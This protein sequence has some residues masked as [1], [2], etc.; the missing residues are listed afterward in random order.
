LK[1]AR[2]CRNVTSF[3]MHFRLFSLGLLVACLPAGYAQATNDSTPAPAKSAAAERAPVIL[4]S[5]D[6]FRWDYCAQHPNET[7]HF[8]KLASEGVA[9]EGLI[10][11]FPSNTFPNHY[12]I[13]TGLYPSHSGI[14]NNRMF[15]PTLGEKFV[16]K[17]TKSARD[18]RWWGGEPIWITAVKQGRTSACYFWP[19]SEAEIK[20]AHATYWK[21]YD[22]SVAFSKR[23]D[24]LVGWL[25]LPAAER[26]AVVAFYFEETNSTG[27]NFGPESPELP[28][29]LAKLDA[30]LGAM[31][32]RF[33]AEH[34]EVN[35]VLV[36]DHGMTP[37][38][39]KRVIWLNDYID[40]D[41]VQ[42]DFDETVGGI[43]PKPGVDATALVA[44]LSRMPYMHVY[45][46]EDLPARLH[47]DPKNP[48][49][50][51]IWIVPDE[52]AEIQ[53]KSVFKSL[54]SGLLKGQ[55]GYDP[56]FK[57]MHGIFIAHGPAF[58]R[59]VTVPEVEN[60]HIYNLLCAAAGL[61]PAPNDG[62]DRL[63]RA[64]LQ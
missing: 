44:K 26:P 56:A 30:E 6:G 12:A 34:L 13:V 47:V 28:K 10:P 20:G 41:Q 2:Q 11:V 57:S 52:G 40:L 39:A 61:K 50:P 46:A 38:D 22:Y 27:H 18:S 59:G 3:I 17:E 62:D 21:P 4:I 8:R 23:L 29:T 35:L 7:P 53:Q 14:V 45:R 58:R 48:R 36:S 51:P 54:I 33:A 5:F 42:V 37:T 60:V 24:E 9:A 43:R 31:I 1:S 32:D 16:Y 19:G 49:V 15:D 25:K 55:H 64:A 63:V